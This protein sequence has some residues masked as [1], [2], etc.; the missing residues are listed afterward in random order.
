MNLDTVLLNG[1]IYTMEEEGKSVEAIGIKDGIIQFTGTNKEAEKYSSEKTIDLEGKTVIPGMADSHMHMYAYCQNQALVDLKDACSIEDMIGKMKEKVAHTPDGTWIKG[2]NFDQSKFKENRFPTKADLDRI[3]TRHPIV[4]RRCCLHAIVANSMALNVAGVGK[5]YDGGSGGIVE[6]DKNGEPNGILREQSTKI[7]DEIIP[8]PLSD[9]MEKRRIMQNVFEDMSSKGVTTI[10]TYAAKIWNY[11]EDV[12]LYR[13]FGEEGNLPVRVTVCLDELFEKEVLTEKEKNDPYRM[14]QY[15][16]Y[17]LF[18]DGSLGS[19]SAALQEPY[20][21]DK[22]N[23]GFVVCTQEEL[24]EKVL[25]GYENGLQLAIHAIGDAAL[26]MTLTA[27]ENCLQVTREKGMSKEEQEERLPFRIIHVQMVNEELIARMKKLPLVLDIQ[28]IFL[29]T[30][31]HWI[32]ERIGAE[33]IKGAYCWKTL[34]DEGLIQTGGSDCPVESFDPMKGIY[35]AA[36]RMDFDGQPEGGYYPEERL[37][38]Y[39][40]FCLFTKNVHAATGQQD[41]LGT[42][43]SGKFADLAVLDRDPFE[44]DVKNLLE[45]KVL[46]TF[47][48]GRLVFVL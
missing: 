46:K 19:R 21:D 12:A 37:S 33:R 6:F 40:A 36:T 14:V 47:V 44:L 15:G 1:K 48:A 42:L 39:D 18:T 26:D 16:A 27:I 9:A 10:H 17:K 23:R 41:K 24:N 2:V 4:I 8:D 20:S 22:D 43:E 32:E 38:V 35:A 7:F 30:D 11:E 5:G 29:C 31:L 45:I 28:P 25:K 13:K 3:S 34:K